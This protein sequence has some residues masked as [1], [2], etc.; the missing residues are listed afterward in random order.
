M[1]NI[2][3][4]L[5]NGVAEVL[6]NDLFPLA[7]FTAAVAIANEYEEEPQMLPRTGARAQFSLPPRNEP[8]VD[9]DPESPREP[10]PIPGFYDDEEE[11][12]DL[13]K[14]LFGQEHGQLNSTDQ[15]SD[16]EEEI[17]KWIESQGEIEINDTCENENNPNDVEA[18]S[19]WSNSTS[20]DE[21][22]LSAHSNQDDKVDAFSTEGLE[23]LRNIRVY[24]GLEPD[25]TP[26]AVLY[27]LARFRDQLWEDRGDK[28]KDGIRSS[29]FGEEYEPL[30]FSRQHE[31]MHES[32][33]AQVNIIDWVGVLS[34]HAQTI[35]EQEFDIIEDFLAIMYG[36]RE[37]TGS[38][39]PER[40]GRSRQ[41]IAQWRERYYL[42][43]ERDRSKLRFPVRKSFD[44]K[45]AE[46]PP[47]A[48]WNDFTQ[49]VMRLPDEERHNML[50][51]KD[52]AIRKSEVNMKLQH[53]LATGH[54]LAIQDDIRK[55]VALLQAL[56]SQVN[57]SFFILGKS[58]DFVMQEHADLILPQT[59][60]DRVIEISA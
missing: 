51:T 13:E 17:E 37:W 6:S 36:Q 9:F 50:S 18:S 34:N 31:I 21:S 23:H 48:D 11:I 55:G 8:S 33:L 7:A 30:P 16:T 56:N 28:T 60:P 49:M 52:E 29:Y 25:E 45:P 53:A 22:D 12:E 4:N 43:G 57:D 47:E 32:F 39:Y 44:G 41:E 40:E 15:P 27:K 2:A 26:L 5:A 20:S 58:I 24:L 42:H 19:T 1:L 59:F 46:L 54:F 35:S 38:E 10:S 14:Q 3:T